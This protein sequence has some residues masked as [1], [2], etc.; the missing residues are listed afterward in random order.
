MGGLAAAHVYYFHIVVCMLRKVDKPGVGT[1]GDQLS[2]SQKFT[3]VDGAPLPLHVNAAIDVAAP[4]QNLLLFRSDYRQ[5]FHEFCIHILTSNNLSCNQYIM[6]RKNVQLPLKQSS[7][8]H[9]T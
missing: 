7:A 3:A 6:N 4:V 9:H 8:A 5:L 1:D 2:G